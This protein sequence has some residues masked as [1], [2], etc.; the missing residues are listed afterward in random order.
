MKSGSGNSQEWSYTT[1]GKNVD[2]NAIRTKTKM[3]CT[4]RIQQP[5]GAKA[6][7][8]KRNRK[9]Q[10]CTKITP[11]RG[12]YCSGQLQEQ[13]KCLIRSTQGA[14][15]QGCNEVATDAAQCATAVI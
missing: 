5:R 13:E 3:G 4:H 15:K 14:A 10:L 9:V 2:G 11:K 7:P 8:T 1:E 6:N 12:R